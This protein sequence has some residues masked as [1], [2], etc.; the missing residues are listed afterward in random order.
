M[1]LI[2]KRALKESLK[3]LVLKKPINKITIADITD[4]CGINR[5]TFYYHFKDIY[6]L[7]EWTFVDGVAEALEDKKT[8]DTWEQGFLRVFQ[9]FLE[10]KRILI[11]VYRSIGLE[12]IQ[13]FLYRIAK[14]LLLGVVEELAVGVEVSDEDKMFIADFCKYVFVGAL[15]DWIKHG[16]RKD[17]QK[18]I[19]RI[20]AIIDGDMLKALNKFRID[21]INISGSG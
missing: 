8:Y 3:I 10:N 6:N 7:I 19:N 17:P 11:N 18:I 14:D 15:V 13:D 9:M 4:H 16:M 1:T 20:S 5:M 21:K 2:T 12:H